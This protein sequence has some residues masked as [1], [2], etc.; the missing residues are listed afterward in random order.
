VS[1]CIDCLNWEPEAAG[2]E[3]MAKLGFAVCKA[4]SMTKGHTF[5]G[6]HERDCEHFLKAAEGIPEKRLKWMGEAT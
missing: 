1:K 2:N 3:K 5:A 6:L 4:R